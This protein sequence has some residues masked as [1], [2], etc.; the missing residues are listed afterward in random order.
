MLIYTEPHDAR[1]MVS[2]ARLLEALQKLPRRQL[3]EIGERLRAKQEAEDPRFVPFIR[4][5]LEEGKADGDLATQILRVAL[6]IGELTAFVLRAY[7]SDAYPLNTSIWYMVEPLHDTDRSIE[8]G[9]LALRGYPT[10]ELPAPWEVDHRPILVRKADV[11]QF[12]GLR[13]PSEAQLNRTA[14]AI[15]KKFQRTYPGIRMKK[16]AFV[17]EMLATLCG[18]LKTRALEMWEQHAQTEWR[19]GGRR[20][21]TS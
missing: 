6:A 3:E 12:L 21:R 10:E 8:R 16:A 9:I 18:C 5:R 20:P 19:E 2:L 15:I 14:K 17:D 7:T 4:E 1:G 13:P 11:R